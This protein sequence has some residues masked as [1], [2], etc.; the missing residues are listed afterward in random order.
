VPAALEKYRKSFFDKSKLV[1]RLQ[2]DGTKEKVRETTTL[3]INGKSNEIVVTKTPLKATCVTRVKPKNITL[4][5]GSELVLRGADRFWIEREL[6]NNQKLALYTAEPV[7]KL[8]ENN[9]E[10]HTRYSLHLTSNTHKRSLYFYDAA[11]MP[12]ESIK[13]IG[14]M[15]TGN[16]TTHWA[17]DATPQWL[18][19][20]DA[21]CVRQWISAVKGMFNK[22]HN[23]KISLR[24]SN[25]AL[26]LLWWWEEQDG[27]YQKS[28]SMPFNGDATAT[29]QQDTQAELNPKDAML[30]FSALSSLPLTNS[31]KI[32][33]GGLESSED[34]SL[35]VNYETEL[36]KYES[37]LPNY[38]LYQALEDIKEKQR[39]TAKEIAKHKAKEAKKGS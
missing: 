7:D 4:H 29:I 33:A 5:K 20:F 22:P 9:S 11:E 36:A 17:I 24:V 38:D 21:E 2:P 3:L 26:T 32:Q 13:S 39:K 14:F 31:V 16:L 27:L 10:T 12:E 34:L 23:R 25:D 15:K 30:L 28:F 18:A 1:E 6:L 35:V 19:K 8:V 37:A